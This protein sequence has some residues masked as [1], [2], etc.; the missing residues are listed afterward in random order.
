MLY[1]QALLGDPR[2]ELDW[3]DF[4]GR[5]LSRVRTLWLTR[6]GDSEL[7]MCHGRSFLPG[8]CQHHGPPSMMFMVISMGELIFK[9]VGFCSVPN[10]FG[11]NP[12]SSDT[13]PYCLLVTEGHTIGVPLLDL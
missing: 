9:T 11:Q 5:L 6:L 1:P 13:N 2:A 8:F 3:R 7:E 4:A 12:L 10:I